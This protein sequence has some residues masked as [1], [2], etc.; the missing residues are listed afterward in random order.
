MGA[1][2]MSFQRSAEWNSAIQQI[3]KSALPVDGTPGVGEFFVAAMVAAGGDEFL[4]GDEIGLGAMRSSLR[5]LVPRV[6]LLRPVRPPRAA[7]PIIPLRRSNPRW[8]TRKQ[9][10]QPP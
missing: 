4:G 5:V 3:G 9:A 2:L 1:A 10:A 6:W 7:L 8:H